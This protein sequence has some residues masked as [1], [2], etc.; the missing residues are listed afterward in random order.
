MT[1]KRRFNLIPEPAESDEPAPEILDG[2]EDQSQEPGTM[3]VSRKEQER[4][5]QLNVRINTQLKR[6]ASAKATLEGK[7]MV[8]IIEAFL[9]AYVNEESAYRDI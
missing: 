7:T 2:R 6:R 9:T 8:D 4:Q 1:R 3:S 5:S